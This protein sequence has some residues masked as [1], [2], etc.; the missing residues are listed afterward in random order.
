MQDIDK[1]D[2]FLLYWIGDIM[3]D[4]LQWWHPVI[5]IGLIWFIVFLLFCQPGRDTV[6]FKGRSPLN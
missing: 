2:Y 6:C 1:L 4:K 5:V 3:L